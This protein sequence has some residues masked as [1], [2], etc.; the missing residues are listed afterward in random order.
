MVVVNV[1]EIDKELSNL[2]SLI[3]DYELNFMNLYKELNDT[4]TNWVD[5]KSKKFFDSIQK[6]KNKEINFFTEIK[7]IREIYKYIVMK[8]KDIGNLIKVKISDKDLIIE[9]YVKTIGEVD[10]ILT[11]FKGLEVTGC[12]EDEKENINKQVERLNSVKTNLIDSKIKVKKLLENIEDIE[13][14]INYKL[15]KI[16]IMAI[17]DYDI[18]EYMMEV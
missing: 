14:E 1:I 15:S 6:E 10:E 2:N 18:S 3:D 5:Q 4:S 16:D 8:Y 9:K 11:L 7:S 17:R 13:K 12:T